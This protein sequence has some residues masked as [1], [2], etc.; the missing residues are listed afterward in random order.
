MM[1]IFE[2]FNQQ[3][4]YS[5]E[6]SKNIKDYRL[7][8]EVTPLDDYFN[9]AYQEYYDCYKGKDYFVVTA[10]RE[11]PFKSDY[12]WLGDL[13]IDKENNVIDGIAFN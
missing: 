7:L 4:N 8:N 10:D 6:F 9:E 5:T 13:V 2:F 12:Y 11:I 1:D 3:H